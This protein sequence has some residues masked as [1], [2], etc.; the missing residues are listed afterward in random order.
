MSKGGPMRALR[1][2]LKSGG[3]AV[4]PADESLPALDAGF[5]PTSA[6]ESIPVAPVRRG[7][8][9]AIADR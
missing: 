2:E 1:S 7:T 9:E 8:L 4:A 6:S 5:H 3:E